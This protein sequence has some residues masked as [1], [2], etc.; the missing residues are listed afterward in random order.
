MRKAPTRFGAL[1]GAGA[2]LAALSLTA[3]PAEACACGALLGPEGADVD[4]EAEQAAIAW[5]GETERIVLSVNALTDTSHAALLIPTPSKATVG[6]ASPALFDELARLT[7]PEVETVTQWWPDFLNPIETKKAVEHPIEVLD[8]VDV[9]PVEST[10]LAA[11]DA[12]GLAD[13]LS[14]NEVVMSDDLAAALV[15]YIQE[16]WYYVVLR[17][18]AEDGPINGSLPPVSLTFD[19]N[20][21]IYPMRLSASANDSQLVRTYTFAEH[22]MERSDS[23]EDS[24]VL[25]AGPVA[26]TDFVDQSAVEFAQIGGFLTASQHYIDSPASI[27]A[28]FT[29]AAASEDA[30][31]S[32]VTTV[33]DHKVIFGAPAGPTLVFGGL[34]LIGA[35]GAIWSYRSRRKRLRLGR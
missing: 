19:S 6:E 1:V 35:G 16:K 31:Y 29:F 8:Q 25:W 28:D 33:I 4:V 5:D 18:D 30:E 14:E 17:L 13:W 23:S 3:V 11:T 34:I 24:H 32:G 22:R 21:L 10:V 2:L 9:G 7:S 20:Q 26:P 27:S 12:D 15:P